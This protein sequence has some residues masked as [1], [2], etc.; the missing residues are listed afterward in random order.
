MINLINQHS[1][2]IAT[3]CKK[4][5]VAKLEVFGSAVLGNFNPESSDMDFLVKFLPL[6]QGQYAN[7]YFG[8]LFDLEDLFDRSID[9]VMPNAIKNPYFLQAINQHR[10]VLYAA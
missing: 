7:A 5:S 4:H 6:E 3:L 9:L 10:E 2:E 8:L 1:Q